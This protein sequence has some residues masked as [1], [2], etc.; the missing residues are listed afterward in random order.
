MKIGN[1]WVD[2]MNVF[3]LISHFYEEKGN[4]IEAGFYW[5]HW[6]IQGLILDLII[7]LLLLLILLIENN[8]IIYYGFKF[9]LVVLVFFF[10]EFIYSLPP[11]TL[12]SGF[13]R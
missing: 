2:L 9:L 8:N 6:Q 13:D 5:V 7:P 11:N 1:L 12:W 3:K 10:R 4:T